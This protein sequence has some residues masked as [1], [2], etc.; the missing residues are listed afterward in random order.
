MIV[1]VVSVSKSRV[2][3]AF[4]AIETSD[5]RY[6]CWQSNDKRSV[7]PWDP[8]EGEQAAQTRST[9]FPWRLCREDLCSEIREWNDP[10]LVFWFVSC[11]S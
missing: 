5:G 11:W 3:R 2:F 7:Q 10:A 4:D 8:D 9:L 6:F 1:V